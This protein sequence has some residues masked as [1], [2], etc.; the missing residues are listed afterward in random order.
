MLFKKIKISKIKNV[1]KKGFNEEAVKDKM[2]LLKTGKIIPAI[3]VRPVNEELYWLKD[4]SHRIEAHKRLA[5]E[6]IYALVE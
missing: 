1:A 5:I 2:K 4:G 6:S 3:K